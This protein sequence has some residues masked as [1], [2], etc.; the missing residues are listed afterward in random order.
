MKPSVEVLGIIEAFA[1]EAGPQLTFL[2]LFSTVSCKISGQPA[3]QPASLL[4]DLSMCLS[5]PHISAFTQKRP[6]AGTLFPPA[7]FF[8][9]IPDPALRYGGDRSPAG[10]L[11]YYGGAQRAGKFRS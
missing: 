6:L 8:P 5:S 9:Y 3:S 11:G 10:A 2:M 4:A 1:S 7:G